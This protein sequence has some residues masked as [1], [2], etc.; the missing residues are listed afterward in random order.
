MNIKEV[1][2]FKVNLE[3]RLKEVLTT[4]MKTEVSVS[5]SDSLEEVKM[6]VRQEARE[7]DRVNIVDSNFTFSVESENNLTFS[8][9]SHALLIEGE[10]IKGALTREIRTD[11]QTLLLLQRAIK[12]FFLDEGLL[13]IEE[14]APIEEEVEV[15]EAVEV[16]TE[17]KPS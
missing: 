9:Y 16:N 14:P 13:V 2:T 8:G 6:K 4:M 12:G 7:T 17:E 11:L 10:M 1:K 15:I 5:F 3:T